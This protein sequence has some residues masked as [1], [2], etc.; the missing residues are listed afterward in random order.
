[1]AKARLKPGARTARAP[2]LRLLAFASSYRDPG[3]VSIK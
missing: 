1:M 3:S 2:R